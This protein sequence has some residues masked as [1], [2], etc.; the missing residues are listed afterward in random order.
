MRVIIKP[1]ANIRAGTIEIAVTIP[2]IQADSSR[3]F[4]F[5]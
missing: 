1:G 3:F 5:L 2:T 4:A